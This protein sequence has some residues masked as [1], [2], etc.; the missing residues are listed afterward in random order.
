MTAEPIGRSLHVE[1]V[2]ASP[3]Q[4]PLLAN[5]LQLYCHDFSESVDIEIGPDGKYPYAS[6]PL[7]WTEP[8]RHPVLVTVN[9]AP[10]GFALVKRAGTSTEFKT[11]WDMEEFF[12]VRRYRRRG[13]GTRIAK[14]VFT[15]HLGRWEIRVLTSNHSGLHFWDRAITA[16]VGQAVPSARI[17]KDSRDW[18]LFSFASSPVKK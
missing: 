14:E 2:R 12:V 1:L 10:A 13:I 7:Y 16:F 17:T 15:R 8:H 9:G 18:Q 5:L 4:Q 3:E 11:I 6:L